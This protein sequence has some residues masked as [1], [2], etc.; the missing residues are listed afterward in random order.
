[1]TAGVAEKGR[2]FLLK[3]STGVTPVNYQTVGGARVSSIQINGE[4]VNVSDKDSDG[5]QVLLAGAGERSVTIN[6]SGVFKDT[7]A[8][9]LMRTAA[10]NQTIEDFQVL[11]ENGDYF[12][13]NFIVSTL[14]YT[15]ENNGAVTY[16]MTLAS[17]GPV[18]FTAV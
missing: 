7:A 11:F 13:G 6:A 4:T 12:A 10:M 9:A 17:S 5:W 16:S 1:M 8:E 2:A 18:T 14:E 15:G 3:H